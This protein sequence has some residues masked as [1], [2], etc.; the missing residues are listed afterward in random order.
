[1]PERSADT[2]LFI[3][4]LFFLLLTAAAADP[5]DNGNVLVVVAENLVTE[6]APTYPGYLPGYS[7]TA[8]DGTVYAKFGLAMSLVMAPA[9]FTVRVL[10]LG[11]GDPQVA[12]LLGVLV[13]HFVPS[14]I[15][16]LTFLMLIRLGRAIKMTRQ[17]AILGAAGAIVCTFTWIYFRVFYSE[18]L[19]TLCAVGV[20]AEAIGARPHNDGW[21]RRAALAG[22]FGGLALLTKPT[23]GLILAAGGIYLAWDRS[24]RAVVINGGI[25]RGIAYTVGALPGLVA[26]MAYNVVRS[27]APLSMGYT[28]G[29]DA[30][31]FTTPLH[32]GLYGL[33]LSPGKGLV[34]YAPLALLGAIGWRGRPGRWLVWS[35]AIIQLLLIARWWS[36]HGAESWGPRLIVPVIP[37]LAL[38]AGEWLLKRRRIA[39]VAAGFGLVIQLLGISLSWP[40]YYKRVPY[41]TWAEAMTRV[42]RDTPVEALGKDN[43]RDVHFRPTMSPIV[44]HVWLLSHLGAATLDS[45]PWDGPFEAAEVDYSIDWWPLTARGMGAQAL[46]LSLLFSLV[47]LAG[48]IVF[49]RAGWLGPAPPERLAK[50]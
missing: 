10:S 35:L 7:L 41:E 14:L 2:R 11:L 33:F 12:Q 17:A 27:G 25:H 8:P 9:V 20:C 50:R 18:G 34:W 24:I 47:F 29:I 13:M 4:A 38:P 36:W 45:A 30:F 26:A 5:V 40:H 39:L 21:A 1:M 43:L 28:D 32:E 42:G 16:A 31:G 48:A 15:G 22:F 6:G 3:G 49:L 37:L 44:G 19:M 23:G 46:G